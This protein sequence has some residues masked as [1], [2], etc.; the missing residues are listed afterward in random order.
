MT[1][2]SIGDRYLW[3]LMSALSRPMDARRGE[4]FAIERRFDFD[5]DGVMEISRQDVGYWK[6][7]M[8]GLP[9]MAVS[10][11]D[12]PVEELRRVAPT[13]LM[14]FEDGR[15]EDPIRRGA[16]AHH[17][18]RVMASGAN[19]S[20]TYV[21]LSFWGGVVVVEE[22]AFRDFRPD[23]RVVP[24]VPGGFGFGFIWREVSGD[25]VGDAWLDADVILGKYISDRLYPGLPEPVPPG[26]E[27]GVQ[28]R[29]EERLGF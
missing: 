2:R 14:I 16:R 24:D 12:L 5:A 13:A 7:G 8:H 15:H 26:T 9:D 19:L 20:G 11:F 29:M 21:C 6:R 23:H 28:A 17:E 27:F 10:I 22:N 25:A 1:I 3:R 4:V 18:M